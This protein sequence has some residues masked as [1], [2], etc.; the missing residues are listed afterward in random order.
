MDCC[1]TGWT[2][3]QHDLFASELAAA[4]APSTAPQGP[5]M[6]APVPLAVGTDPQKAH[7]LPRIR[8]GDDYWAQGY[9]EPSRNVGQ[10][11]VQIHGGM[12]MTEELAVGRYFRRATTIE[13]QLG[14]VD[15]PLRRVERQVAAAR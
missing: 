14:A 5:R 11:A 7:Y 12:G 10:G 6:V 15:W 3:L 9:S 1:G 4:D 2:P 13:A 8:S